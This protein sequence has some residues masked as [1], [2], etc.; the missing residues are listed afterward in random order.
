MR[1]FI[2]VE[3]PEEVKRQISELQKTLIFTEQQAKCNS[4]KEQHITLK[5]LG[6]IMDSKIP[7]IIAALKYVSFN[8]FNA[9]I[10]T[11][12]GFANENYLR[13]AW[14]IT[15]PQKEFL[16]LK[17]KIDKQLKFVKSKKEENFIPH[18]TLARFKYV[19]DRNLVIEKVKSLKLKAEFIVDSFK[20]M[21][22]ILTPKGHVYEVIESFNAKD[23]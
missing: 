2:A 7:K 14:F 22:S 6:E 11:N 3:L 8:K 15:E 4:S 13:V 16:D 17:Q 5:F 9:K 23:L 21:K 1:L 20:L 19:N 10:E 18:I 12:A